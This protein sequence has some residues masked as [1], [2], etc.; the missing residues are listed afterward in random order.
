MSPDK[1]KAE[2]KEACVCDSS[3]TESST[4]C[5]NDS[6]Q[7]QH[8]IQIPSTFERSSSTNSK[9]VIDESIASTT[10]KDNQNNMSQK[11][12]TYLEETKCLEFN[13]DCPL[14]QESEVS[15]QSNSDYT[16]QSEEQTRTV[17]IRNFS[18]IAKVRLL[19]VQYM[20]VV[21]HLKWLSRCFLVFVGSATNS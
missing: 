16:G 13:S 10:P 5:Q 11:S 15:I 8:Q 1:R 4:N 9:L 19:P 21:H 7:Q 3:I 14:I 12:S 18:N 17:I 2:C 6:V 20:S